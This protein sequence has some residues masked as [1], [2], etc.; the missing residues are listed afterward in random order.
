[1]DP[2]AACPV[3]AEA[4]LAALEAEGRALDEVLH[5]LHGRWWELPTR[6]PAWS[7]R[8]LLGHVVRGVDRIRAYLEEP[9]PPAALTDW[10]GY[11]TPS[12]GAEAEQVAERAKGYAALYE[13]DELV[14]MWTDLRQRSVELARAAAPD[15]VIPSVIAPLRLDHYLTSRVLEVTVHGLDLRDALGLEQVATP[16]ALEVTCAVLDGLLGGERPA[17]LANDP[18]GFV[19]AATGRVSFSDDRLPVLS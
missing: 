2:T 7:V 1:M 8:E 10:L 12:D 5:G 4:S 19:L 16:P 17:A 3:P 6:L 11:W 18:I 15:V 14:T 13:P 9:T